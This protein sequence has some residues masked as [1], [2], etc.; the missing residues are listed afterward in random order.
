[1]TS[2]KPPRSDGSAPSTSSFQ[3][4]ALGVALVH[5]EQVAGEEVGLLAALGAADL[6][7]DVAA[8]VGV[9]GQEQDLQLGRRGARCRPRPRSTS[10][11]ITSRSSPSSVGAASPWPSPGRSVRCRSS[12]AALDDRLELLVAP[13]E[14]ARSGAGR[15]T[16]RGRPRRASTSTN[17]RSRSSR[18]SSIAR[19]LP[20]RSRRRTGRTQAAPV[21]ARRRRPRPGAARRG[22]QGPGDGRGRRASGTT[23]TSRGVGRRA[24]P[25]VGGRA[26]RGRGRRRPSRP[27]RPARRRRRSP[28]ATAAGT[29]L[30]VRA[31][32][33]AAR[34]G[35]SSAS[36]DER[37]VGDQHGRAASARA[38]A[39]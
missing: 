14:L 33:T 34:P 20:A 9:L 26:G 38:P 23:S 4:C 3:P 29:S 31:R 21:A 25:G 35:A 16:R 18:R 15:R 19:R 36:A 28:T 5:L 17:S 13:G 30:Q 6:D 24:Q 11:R 37:R 39:G 12:A 27:R 32:G 10:A 8:V 7:D 1:M 2:L 22:G